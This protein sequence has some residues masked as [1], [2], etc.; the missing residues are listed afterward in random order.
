MHKIMHG[1]GD[2][3]SS[4]WFEKLTGSAVTRARADPM[5]V[6]CKP[7]TLEIRR[8]FFS[9]RVISDWNAVPPEVKSILIP[10]KFKAALRK[11]Q[12]GRRNELQLGQNAA[13]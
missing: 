6:K 7:G 11:W 10:G 4:E 1:V 13:R 9:N 5:N 2:I 8:N 12:E 3:D